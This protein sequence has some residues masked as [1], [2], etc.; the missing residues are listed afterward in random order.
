[1]DAALLPFEILPAFKIHEMTKYHVTL[2][3]GRRFN[4]QLF[5]L[6]MNK[7]RYEKLPPDLKKVIDDN[8]GMALAE[9]AARNWLEFEVTG[10]QAVRGRGNEL[11]SLSKSESDQ[12]EVLSRAA[13][14]KWIADVKRRGID[15]QKMVDAARA[16]IA[17]YRGK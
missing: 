13:I 17:K 15:G 11:I 3:G 10:E 9:K 8:S 7:P 16:S 14:D 5:I 6:L 4:A 12:I 1:V 2:E